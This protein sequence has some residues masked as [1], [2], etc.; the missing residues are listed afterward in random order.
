[1]QP[2]FDTYTKRPTGDRL[3][4]TRLIYQE[5]WRWLDDAVDVLDVGFGGGV[6]M[7]VAPPG[8]R[9]RGVDSDPAAVA[10][11]PDTAVLSSA[12]ELPFDDEEFDA[13]HAA[14]VIEHL[15]DPDRFVAEA[16][17][18]LRPRG[19]LIVATPDIER[20]RFEF[21]VDHTHRRPFTARSLEQILKMHGLRMERLEHGLMAQ[22]RIEEIASRRGMSV[23]TRF[24][25]RSRLG[26]RFGRELIAFARLGG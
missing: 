25:I 24:R 23:Q 4:M 12:E 6:F 5:R 19:R 17:R 14:H 2:Y 18:V 22:T 9:V 1:L 20:Y 3:E 13:V 8:R 7:D 21:W 10:T 16:A 26:P 11:R 15:E